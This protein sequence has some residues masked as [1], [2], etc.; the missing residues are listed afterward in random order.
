MMVL[1]AFV[2]LSG[3]GM[4]PHASSEPH[5]QALLER[6]TADYSAL[7]ALSATRSVAPHN[8]TPSTLL[9]SWF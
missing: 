6:E 5:A 9:R 4:L 7:V 2:S 8:N 3:S 1:F